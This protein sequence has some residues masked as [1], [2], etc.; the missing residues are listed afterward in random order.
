MCKLCSFCQGHLNGAA[1]PDSPW[2]LMMIGNTFHNLW[3]ADT[4]YSAEVYKAWSIQHVCP[5]AEPHE[6]F[7]EG[8][9]YQCDDPAHF[10]VGRSAGVPCLLLS[11]DQ[12]HVGFCM[13]ILHILAAIEAGVPFG[14]RR[15]ASGWPLLCSWLAGLPNEESPQAWHMLHLLE[16]SDGLERTNKTRLEL[17]KSL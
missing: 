5:C 2:V 1:F 9:V 12:T 6:P 14:Y 17:T 15:S 11:V 4:L 8:I 13:F 3:D 7:E 16:A 10:R